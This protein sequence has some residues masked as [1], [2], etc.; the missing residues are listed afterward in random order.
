M[1]IQTFRGTQREILLHQQEYFNLSDACNASKPSK[2]WLA[3]VR[4]RHADMELDLD[5]NWRNTNRTDTNE[6]LGIV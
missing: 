2:Y 6:Y 1:A 4:W 3:I 5:A